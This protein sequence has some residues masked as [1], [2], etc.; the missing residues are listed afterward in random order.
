MSLPSA[1]DRLGRV[2]FLISGHL[3]LPGLHLLETIELFR[4][5]K[6]AHFVFLD[7]LLLGILTLVVEHEKFDESS[8]HSRFKKLGKYF[9]HNKNLAD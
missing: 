5:L 1:S 6:G 3:L 2:H 8:F 7:N 9:R 4:D